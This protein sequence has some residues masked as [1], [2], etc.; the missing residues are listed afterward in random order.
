MQ[1]ERRW[2]QESAPGSRIRA[3]YWTWS[4]TVAAVL[5]GGY[6]VSLY[7][8]RIA[9]ESSVPPGLY[10]LHSVTA[11]LDR[12]TLVLLRV[13]PSM[14]R[15]KSS[16]LTLLKPV[17]AVAG[18]EV[19]IHEGELRI[20]NETYGLVYREAGGYAL[21]QFQG[22]FP[23]AD[24]TIFVASKADRSMDS[25]YFSSIPLSEVRAWAT[26]LWTWRKKG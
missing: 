2:T 1:T 10:L 22:C 13:P 5:V 6:L 12:G 19:C 25:R 9:I 11:P 8:V 26:P 7:W 21:P 18:E 15:W 4:T 16:W 3:R 23:V 20:G 14:H 24:G 17:A